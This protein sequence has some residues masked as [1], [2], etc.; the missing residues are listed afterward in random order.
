MS[1][2]IDIRGQLRHPVFDPDYKRPQANNRL[3]STNRQAETPS[4]DNHVS[5]SSSSSSSTFEA[6]TSD[7]DSWRGR[8]PTMKTSPTSMTSTTDRKTVTFDDNLRQERERGRTAA[9]KDTS[10]SSSNGR[11]VDRAGDGGDID[12]MERSKKKTKIRKWRSLSDAD[13]QPIGTRTRQRQREREVADSQPR[14]ST[15]AAKDGKKI[16]D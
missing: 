3:T 14:K 12:S 7:D 11:T 9:G 1:V 4:R 2:S 16:G 13:S 10:T 5:S 8:R 6:D 15:T